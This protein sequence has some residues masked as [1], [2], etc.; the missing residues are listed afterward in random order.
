MTGF[1]E[2]AGVRV[3]GKGLGMLDSDSFSQAPVTR[4]TCPLPSEVCRD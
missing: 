2:L 4:R 3:S 1:E